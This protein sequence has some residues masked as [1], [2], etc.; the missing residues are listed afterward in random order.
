M[1]QAR[2]RRNILHRDIV[3]QLT[4]AAEGFQVMQVNQVGERLRCD[5]ARVPEQVQVE[6]TLEPGEAGV[7]IIAERPVDQQVTGAFLCRPT[8]SA[9]GSCAAEADPH[10]SPVCRC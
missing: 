2:H 6:D 7:S 1:A 9:M 3:A 4:V 5:A 10:P 8:A